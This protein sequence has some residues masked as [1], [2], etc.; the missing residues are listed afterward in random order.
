MLVSLAWKAEKGNRL[1]LRSCSMWKVSPFHWPCY[2]ILTEPP[3]FRL[4]FLH[5]WKDWYQSCVQRSHLLDW[6]SSLSSC[7]SPVPWCLPNAWADFYLLAL[8]SPTILSSTWNA[9]DKGHQDLHLLWVIEE[10]PWFWRR[11]CVS[12]GW[13]TI[14]CFR[15]TLLAWF[16]Y[17]SIGVL[18]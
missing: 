4:V 6:N 1:T 9:R 14:S 3:W 10:Q 5:R 16:I 2:L 12:R 15:W 11:N 13:R 17:L 18:M 8:F 7:K